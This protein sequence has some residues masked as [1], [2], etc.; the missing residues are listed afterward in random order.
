[1]TSCPRAR[2]ASATEAPISPVPTIASRWTATRAGR[3]ASARRG[4]RRGRATGGRSGAGRRASRSATS[5]CSSS[6]VLGAAEALGDVLA[7]ELE[8]HAAGPDALVPAR[9]EEALDLGMIASK[10]RVLRPPAVRNRVRVHRVAGPDDRVLR[11]RAPRAGAAAAAPRR[12]SAPMRAINVS[13]PGS[14]SRVQPLAELDDLVG[15]RRR[16]ELA[17]RAGCGRP[18]RTRR[19]RRRAAACARRSRACGP[20]SRTSRR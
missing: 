8:V 16:A 17:R 14:R 9:G 1:M 18:R 11:R 5:S 7:G 13:R 10:W 2:A 19:A 12:G 6:S 3:A 15:R 4:G 20:S